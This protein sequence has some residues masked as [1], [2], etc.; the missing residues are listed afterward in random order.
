MLEEMQRRTLAELV[1]LYEVEPEIKDVFVE[2]RSDRNF[3]ENHVT[4]GL[5]SGLCKF[6]AVSDRV[7]ISDGELIA[8]GLM[9]GARGRVIWL[10]QQL[11]E[12]GAA[13]SSAAFV[14]DKD[15]ASL[16]A[17]VA[18]DVRGLFFTDYSS[19]EAY[20]LNECTMHKVLRI[21]VGAP[22]YVTAANLLSGIK[23]ALV[24]LFVLR[25]CLRDSLTGATIPPKVLNRWSLEDHSEERI[26]E[27]LRLALNSVSARDRGAVTVEKLYSWYVEFMGKVGPDFR[28]YVNGHDVSLILVRYLKEECSQV[29]NSDSRRPLQTPSVMEIVLMSSIETVHL[30]GEGLFV[31]LREWVRGECSEPRSADAISTHAKL[32]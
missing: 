27:V 14:A 18:T 9:A 21:S 19:M 26:M 13:G 7:H 2:G 31:G 20:S 24:S 6:Y 11:A 12:H 8:A 1:T 4:G 5:D 30:S 22:P 3:L 29:F 10:A 28:D 16:G 32:G 23:E 25:L 15:F 17:D